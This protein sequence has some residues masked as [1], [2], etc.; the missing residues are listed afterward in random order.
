MRCA[1]LPET[2]TEKSATA[3]LLAPTEWRRTAW[4]P[5]VFRHVRLSLLHRP[6]E[7]AILSL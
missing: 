3:L 1:A 6:E 2:V 5:M 4:R 7:C